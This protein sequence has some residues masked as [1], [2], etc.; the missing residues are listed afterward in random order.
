MS[1]LSEIIEKC[2]TAMRAGIPIIYIKTDSY[3]IIK[4]IVDSQELVLLLTNMD[5][6]T[7]VTDVKYRQLKNYENN[8]F[9]KPVNWKEKL[10]NTNTWGC[11]HIVTID[12]SNGIE[13]KKLEGYVRN[14]MRQRADDISQH[15]TAILRGSALI[16]YSSTVQLSEKLLQY[17][18]IVEIGYPDR[19]EIRE[20]VQDMAAKYGENIEGKS[21]EHICSYLQGFNRQEAIIALNKVLT[22]EIKS[23]EKSREIKWLKDEKEVRKIIQSQKKQKLQ[24]G[25]QV[26]NLVSYEDEEIGGMHKLTGHIKN[27][28]RLMEDADNNQRIYGVH[29][30]KGI[31]LCGI[32]GCGKSLAA[33]L[34]AKELELPLLQMDIGNLMGGIVGQ[35]EENMRKALNL[36][37]A[38]APCVLWIDELEKGFSGLR[39]GGDSD[40]GTFKRM[41][42]SLLNWMQENTKPCFIFATANDIGGLPKEF[43]RSGRFDELYAVYLP[44][45]SECAD[46]FLACTKKAVSSTKE[47]RKKIAKEQLIE[48]SALTQEFYLELINSYLVRSDGVHIVIGSDIQKIV[49]LALAEESITIRE[50]ETKPITQREWKAALKEAIKQCTVYGDS[51]E[52]IDSIAVGYCRMLRKG[53]KPTVGDGVLFKSEDYH[54]ENAADRKGKDKDEKNILKKN[55]PD[56]INKY[57]EAVYDKLY[58]KINEWAYDVEQMERKRLLEG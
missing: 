30:P 40:G 23:T 34:T 50:S 19:D 45:A 18:E 7:R 32:P 24:D 21:L 46:I 44:T 35:S 20:L 22:R 1:V 38:M 15:N 58:P 14:Y 39:S 36:A 41:F 29:A 6:N 52:N 2:K 28:K 55:K 26:L 10:E 56:S 16:L 12:A 42:G 3:E 33:K 8:N 27:I 25:E 53:L 5:E 13:E 49:N 4:S 17:T 11:P 37:T 51:S 31:L 54:I 47:I 9:I 48:E 43:F 57:D